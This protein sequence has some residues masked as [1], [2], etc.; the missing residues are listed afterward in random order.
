MPNY[1][2]YEGLGPFASVHCPF[3]MGVPLRVQ[4]ADM[5][6]SGIVR[7]VDGDEVTV[8]IPS[9]AVLVVAW[10]NMRDLVPGMHVTVE[11]WGGP[12]SYVVR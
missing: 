3:G 11:P 8:A 2:S 9:H 10:R 6:M 12:G 4:G 7:A 5:L 1:R